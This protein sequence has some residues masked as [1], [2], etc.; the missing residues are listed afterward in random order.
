MASDANALDYVL[1][2]DVA[3]SEPAKQIAALTRILHAAAAGKEVNVHWPTVLRS[4][5][6]SEQA[7]VRRLA[8]NVLPLC[9]GVSLVEWEAVTSTIASDLCS[10][11]PSMRIAALT[12]V[13]SLSDLH[14]F[15]AR[16]K[17]APGQIWIG[18]GKDEAPEVHVA[19]LKVWF[20]FRP[21]VSLFPL[22]S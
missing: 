19:A 7:E 20:S 3:S 16:E 21:R 1:L 6:A 11:D 18:G 15:I 2:E 5:V 13:A 9:R 12:G 17:D 10:F 4:C 8:Y 14:L 22:L